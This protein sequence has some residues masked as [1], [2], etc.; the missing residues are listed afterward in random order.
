MEYH[1]NHYF[2]NIKNERLSPGRSDVSYLIELCTCCVKY[3]V[4]GKVYRIPI[5][6]KWMGY[7]DPHL[8]G[9]KI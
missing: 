9:S 4:S 3:F 6:S 1:G 7:F 5:L 2:F 8:I